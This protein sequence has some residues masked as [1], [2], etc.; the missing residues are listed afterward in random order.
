MK[1]PSPSVIKF[2]LLALVT[3]GVIACSDDEVVQEERDKEL[4]LE[5]VKEVVIATEN[6]IAEE[7]AEVSE[8]IVEATEGQDEVIQQFRDVISAK[9]DAVR[10]EGESMKLENE[11]LQARVKELEEGKR[12]A[13]EKFEELRS[14]QNTLKQDITKQL[15]DAIEDSL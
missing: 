9:L 13:E 1:A 5:V 4:K 8:D 3:S 7:I 6:K 11:A 14:Q 12:A 10:A 2:S 15:V